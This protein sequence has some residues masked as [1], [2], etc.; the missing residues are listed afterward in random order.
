MHPMAEGL[1][2]VRLV[3][4]A[5]TS[6]GVRYA[7]G[8]SMASSLAGEPRFTQDA[9]IT[10]EPFP[11][12][13]AALAACFGQGYYISVPAMVEANRKL[14]S[15]NIINVTT[16]FRVDVFLRKDREFDRSALNRAAPLVVGDAPDQPIQVLTAEDV[17]LFKLEWYRLGDEVSDRQW[18]DVLGLLRTRGDRLQADYVERFA[19]QLGVAD[20]FERAK[21]EV[22]PR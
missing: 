15:F 14:A 4:S 17:L 20:L 22:G 18:N 7:L 11:G 19:R 16:G 10:V 2:E 9:D 3:A 1:R 12:R 8:G 13:E 6:I 21:N 5:L